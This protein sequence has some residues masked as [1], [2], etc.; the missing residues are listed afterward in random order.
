MID[1]GIT[2]SSKS[3]GG[4]N[5]ANID[6]KR[7]SSWIQHP[8]SECARDFVAR[9]DKQQLFSEAHFSRSSYDDDP[10]P[11]GNGHQ[12]TQK[13]PN[14]P[15]SDN[16]YQFNSVQ[17]PD[18]NYQNFNNNESFKGN[19]HEFAKAE[20]NYPAFQPGY[21]G[22]S[23]PF[24]ES[25]SYFSYFQGYYQYDQ[26]YEGVQRQY[27]PPQH[28]QGYG[29]DYKP[30]QKVYPAALDEQDNE[31][32]SEKSNPNLG[33]RKKDSNILIASG[34]PLDVTPYKIFRLFSLYGNVTRIKIMFKKRDT[35]LIQFMDSYQAKLA[36]LYLNGCM[37]GDG[38]IK[39]NTSK[40][41]FIIMPK[42]GTKMESEERM[43]AQDFSRSKEH[44][45]KIAGS[46]NFQNIAPPSKV[47]HL[48]NL[49]KGI[50]E[51]KLQSVFLSVAAFEK[52]KFF[53]VGGKTMA[54]AEFD[55]I[56]T[57]IEVI[58]AFHNYNI[59]GRYIKISFSK[60][61]PENLTK[62]E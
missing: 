46:R 43:L 36:K 48:S 18:Y 55:S 53:D 21:S 29:Y 56:S 28:Y 44:R 15:W 45:Y 24:N 11:S 1:K 38:A 14:N 22:M 39:V 3:Y 26:E 16:S 23:P 47:L 59:E 12:E 61:V 34:F 32:A 33:G 35:A 49:P 13:F 40:S 8:N 41:S 20:E 7:H 51:E 62:E 5:N 31:V 10:N 52:I 2:S 17:S 19:Y 6:P 42:K 30:K 57:A 54:H 37:F 4:M 27:H 9:P 25:P 58:I 60:S 50:G